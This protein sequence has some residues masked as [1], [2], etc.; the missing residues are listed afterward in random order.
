MHVRRSTSKA[1]SRR[2][3]RM[4]VQGLESRV[5]MAA[6]R[7][8]EAEIT[9]V[10]LTERQLAAAEAVVTS[11][12]VSPATT[13]VSTVPAYNSR[14]GAFAQIYLDFNGD[15]T[16]TWGSYQP[17]TTP[18][19]S[20]DADTTTFTDTEQT[21]IQE[22]WARVAEKY[23]PLNVNVTTVDPGNL[24]NRQTF[25]IVVGGNGAWLGAQA[26][27]VAYINGFSNSA[28]NVGFVFSDNLAKYPKYIAE[29][30]AHE[31]GHGFGLNHQATWT[32]GT[33][34]A[35]YSSGTSAVAPIMGNSYSSQRGLWTRGT[36][37]A[38]PTSVQDDLSILA[39]STNGF[40]YRAD[41]YVNTTT[42]AFSLTPNGTTVSA[43]G[44]V[45]NVADKD[46][47]SFNTGGGTVSFTGG[48]VTGGM[49]DM[50]LELRDAANNI[51]AAANSTTFG[52]TLTA[53]VSSG[54][55]Y[56]VVASHGSYGDVGQYTLSGSVQPVVV[57][58][59]AAPTG[60]IATGGNNVSLAW[61]DNA[62]NETGY[63]VQRSTDGGTT[64]VNVATLGTNATN[65]VDNTGAA[66]STYTYRVSA[67]NATQ[68]VYSGNATATLVTSAPTGL[69]ATAASTSQIN[70][71]WNNVTGE[72]G[73]RIERSADGTNWSTLA[74]VGADVTG[75]QNTGLAAGTTYHYRVFATNAGG[76]S[77]ASNAASAATQ[78]AVVVSPIPA[79]PTN[80]VATKTGTTS[81][82]LNWT[83][84]ATNEQGT[85]VEY[86]VNGS[87]WYRLG[88]VGANVT[89]VNIS[90]L[91]SGY[92]YYWRVR[93]YNFNGS[94]AYSNVAYNV[95]G[96]ALPSATASSTTTT[97][98]S[99]FST[100]TIAG[101]PRNAP[102]AA[103][104]K[105]VLR[106]G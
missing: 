15:T 63:R 57:Q 96:A 49:L 17:G 61:A 75:F 28:S 19:F 43:A 45:E 3:S 6:D 100:T 80:L 11:G 79:A 81:V 87:T 18:A 23:S 26:G 12:S 10:L 105:D 29:A 68:T 69:T 8:L 48:S 59:V 46:F 4:L 104:N 44:V 32:N 20:Q 14:P 5:L 86:S 74:T 51:I 40:G 102:L 47:F 82:R 50:R 84:N 9:P 90:G 36:T 21:A 62:T 98:T 92:T 95:A 39:N 67:F 42:G 106:R 101:K 2:G 34:T 13:P 89:S 37:T 27:G 93:A 91:S 30:T 99:T 24:N 41:D 25:K 88:N 58:N 16:S 103:A 83:D 97:T 56:V 73:F 94:S 65:F 64:F 38:G 71:A 54:T 53:T 76:A 72:T 70:L 7:G 31:A 35:D 55:Y 78:A 22:V 33:L 52:E 85:T 60:L 66:G 77:A 1:S